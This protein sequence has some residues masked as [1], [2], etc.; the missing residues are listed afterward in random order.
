VGFVV[1]PS[2]ARDLLFRLSLRTDIFVKLVAAPSRCSRVRVLT[3]CYEG[4]IA[5]S[6][7]PCSEQKTRTLETEAVKKL[8]LGNGLKNISQ[9]E[10]LQA[11]IRTSVYILYHPKNPQKHWQMGFFT[12]SPARV[13]QPILPLR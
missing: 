13:R 1:I 9:L 11:I 2:A 7:T 3:F 12:A 8:K 6:S 10:A 4:P 5:R